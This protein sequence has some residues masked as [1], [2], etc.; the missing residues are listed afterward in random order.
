MKGS[1]LHAGRSPLSNAQF[2]LILGTRTQYG[3]FTL[4]HKVGD[5]DELTAFDLGHEDTVNTLM[6]LGSILH[7]WPTKDF[8][9]N[10]PGSLQGIDK[11]LTCGVT[12]SLKRR[13]L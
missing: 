7:A 3:L 10:I 12:A 2:H 11:F 1:C 5:F 13:P 8:I 9:R 4:V 6:A